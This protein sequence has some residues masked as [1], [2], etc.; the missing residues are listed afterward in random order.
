MFLDVFIKSVWISCFKTYVFI[1]QRFKNTHFKNIAFKTTNKCLVKL[2][3]NCSKVTV[4][5]ANYQ[6]GLNYISFYG[7]YR[8]FY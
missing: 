2:V 1:K 4:L 5:G 8:N 7:D 6:K 3:K